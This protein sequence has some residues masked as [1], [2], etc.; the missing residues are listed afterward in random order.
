MVSVLVCGL[1]GHRFESASHLKTDHLD[2]PPVVHDWIIQGL[3]TSALVCATGHI[4]DPVLLVEKGRALCD[5]CLES[6]KTAFVSYER[7]C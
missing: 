2:F 1:T 5:I 4:K 3:C 7:I 6:V